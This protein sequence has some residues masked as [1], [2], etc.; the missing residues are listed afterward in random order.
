MLYD[1]IIP[2]HYQTAVASAIAGK[3]LTGLSNN[4][5]RAVIDAIADVARGSSELFGL[6]ASLNM[7]YMTQFHDKNFKPAN[8]FQEA[9]IAVGNI[10]LIHNKLVLIRSAY[11]NRFLGVLVTSNIDII[12]DCKRAMLIG[13]F[14]NPLTIHNFEVDIVDCYALHTPVLG[15]FWGF[16]CNSDGDVFK[17]E[18]FKDHSALNKAVHNFVNGKEDNLRLFITK[19]SDDKDILIEKLKN[20]IEQSSSDISAKWFHFDEMELFHIPFSR[21]VKQT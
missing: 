19:N 7:Q 21:V 13:S 9:D 16:S 17:I 14:Q 11:E 20:F 2:R 8:I 1:I 15:V 10:Y 6:L 12:I 18:T 3:K 4:D 5:C